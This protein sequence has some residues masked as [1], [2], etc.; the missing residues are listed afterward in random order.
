MPHWIN[1][2]NGICRRGA[3]EAEEQLGLKLKTTRAGVQTLVIDHVEEPSPN[4]PSR[5][6]SRVVGDGEVSRSSDS[7][8]LSPTVCYSSVNRTRDSSR[9]GKRVCGT[10]LALFAALARWRLP[11][12][13]PI[14]SRR[15]AI[16]GSTFVARRAGM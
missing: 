15:S 12:R 7:E 5:T 8:L 4:K 11:N 9:K 3:H 2:A 6:R 16:S 13:N 1:P 14:Y 10:G